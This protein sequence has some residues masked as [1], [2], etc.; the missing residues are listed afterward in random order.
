MTNEKEITEVEYKVLQLLRKNSR[1]S[2]SDIAKEL[3]VSRALVSKVIRSLEEKG[4]KYC[5]EYYEKDELVAFALVNSC[6]GLDD[7]FKLLDGRYMAVIRGNLEELSNALSKIGSTQYFLAV[8]KVG[9]PKLKRRE[10]SCDYCG[11]KI[12]GEPYVVK[13]GRRVYYACCKSCK[14]QL[15]KRLRLKETT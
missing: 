5:V 1:R 8:E 15:T 6:E 12:L 7:C 3:K 13:A 11:E 2:A 14:T 4:V 10:L 9:K